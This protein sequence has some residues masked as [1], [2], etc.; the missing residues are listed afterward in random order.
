MSNFD[1]ALPLE[2]LFDQRLLFM[3][4]LQERLSSVEDCLAK[5][6]TIKVESVIKRS[7]YTETDVNNDIAIL[8]LSQV[9]RIQ[10]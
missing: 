9:I 8:R 7:D 5:A 6:P 3:Q 2:Q 1:V 10:S 4:R